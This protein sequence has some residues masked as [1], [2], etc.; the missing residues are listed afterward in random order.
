MKTL[1]EIAIECGARIVDKWERYLFDGDEIVFDDEAELQAF[2]DRVN[3][4]NSELVAEVCPS[5][6]GSGIIGVKWLSGFGARKLMYGD[7]LYTSPQPPV[8]PNQ[9]AYIKRLEDAL[10]EINTL[11]GLT[12]NFGVAR[13]IACKALGIP[14]TDSKER[15]SFT[16]VHAKASKGAT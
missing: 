6:D 9:S 2:V 1:T 5:K 15:P 14:H 8:A 11:R 10:N 7:K 3:S 13:A 4:R 12:L 16:N